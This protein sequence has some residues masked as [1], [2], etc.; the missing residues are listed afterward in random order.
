MHLFN[1][2]LIYL[3]IYLYTYLFIYLFVFNKIGSLH[4]SFPEVTAKWNS[5]ELQD[6]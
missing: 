3:F 5:N 2:L 4:G 1:Y 6:L